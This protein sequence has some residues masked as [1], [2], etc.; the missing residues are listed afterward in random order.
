MA[1]GHEGV[2]KGGQVE[3]APGIF[4]DMEE[5]KS[6]VE[7]AEVT[8]AKAIFFPQAEAIVSFITPDGEKVE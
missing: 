5:L 1:A 7:A 2:G 3:I 8:G 4:G 6:A